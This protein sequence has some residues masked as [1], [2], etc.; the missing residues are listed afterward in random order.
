MGAGDRSSRSERRLCRRNRFL[1]GG[2]GK[3]APPPSEAKAEDFSMY[4]VS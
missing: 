4:P 2:L 1:G 3:G